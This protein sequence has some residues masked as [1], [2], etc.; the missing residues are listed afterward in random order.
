MIK[1]YPNPFRYRKLKTINNEAEIFEELQQKLKPFL[2]NKFSEINEYLNELDD[3]K[4]EIKIVRVTQNVIKDSYDLI[5]RKIKSNFITKSFNQYIEH[6]IEEVTKEVN[7]FDNYQ[8]N[9]RYLEIPVQP[10]IDKQGFE[11]QLTSSDIVDSILREI[12]IGISSIYDYCS[13][14]IPES[15]DLWE[16]QAFLELEEFPIIAH[17]DL[18][19]LTYECLDKIFRQIQAGAVSVSNWTFSGNMN[20]RIL[21]VVK[22]KFDVPDLLFLVQK[23]IESAISLT[24]LIFVI[25]YIINKLKPTLSLPKRRFIQLN[26]QKIFRKAKKNLSF[27]KFCFQQKIRHLKWE[28]YTLNFRLNFKYKFLQLIFNK[29]I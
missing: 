1:T 2:L 26:P 18:L 29:S 6:Y 28:I 9:L 13:D 12:E 14:I 21:N 25:K 7:F 23:T 3:L 17:D 5:S 22:P 27:K 4:S 19:D 11:V 10:I 16:D 20:N 15:I 24:V 8:K